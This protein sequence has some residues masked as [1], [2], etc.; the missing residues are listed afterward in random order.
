M[1]TAFIVIDDFL[2]DPA[3]LR[4]IAVAQE[5]PELNEPTYFPGRNSTKRVL[6]DGVDQVIQQIIGEP[7]VPAAEDAAHGKF[8][9]AFEGDRGSAGVHID[10]C[11]WSG[12]LYLSLPE[13]CRGGTEFFRHRETG[14]DHAP[15]TGRDLKAMGFDSVEALWTE[16]IWPHT[17][18]RSKWECT[19]QIPMRY[20]RLVLFRPQYWHDAGP[21]F[22]SSLDDGRLVYLLFY[23]N[24][25]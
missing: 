22:G 12:I 6:L 15:F 1:P 24:R 21:G 17:N 11:D 23:R 16:L 18:D 2:T 13:H 10:N 3:Q 14:T 20:N 5:Y 8:R 4:S 9:I 7:L 19:M 25:K